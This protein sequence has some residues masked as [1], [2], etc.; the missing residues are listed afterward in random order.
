M[1][2]PYELRESLVISI[3]DFF[4]TENDDPDATTLASVFITAIQNSGE[5]VDMDEEDLVSLIEDNAE[6][7]EPLQHIL[8]EEFSKNDEL[9]L[10]GDDVVSF[11]EKLLHIE[12]TDSGLEGE[13]EYEEDDYVYEDED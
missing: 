1:R 3:D 8:E 13:M 2:F 7:D 5:D 4:E 10:T 6:L 9:E 11:V 12:W